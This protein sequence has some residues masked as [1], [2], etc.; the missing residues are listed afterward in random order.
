MCNRY[1]TLCVTLLC[2]LHAVKT[3]ETVPDTID[4]PL[5]FQLESDNSD[6]ILSENERSIAGKNKSFKL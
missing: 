2:C 6:D 1:K 5:G 3:E 4:I